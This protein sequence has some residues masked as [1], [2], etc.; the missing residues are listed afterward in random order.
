M[1][2][3][4]CLELLPDIHTHYTVLYSTTDHDCN[5]ATDAMTGG[6]GG[7]IISYPHLRGLSAFDG[8][9]S[10]DFVSEPRRKKNVF[11]LIAV[12]SGPV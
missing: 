12:A 11:F 3:I 7:D 2:H 6:F 9:A 1:K 8:W 5:H 10:I 4:T